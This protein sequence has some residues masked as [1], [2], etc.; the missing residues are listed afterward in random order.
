MISLPAAN[1]FCSSGIRRS[2]NEIFAPKNLNVRRM[3]TRFGGKRAAPFSDM[4]ANS[5]QLYEVL[6]EEYLVLHGSLPES[7]KSRR[8][9]ILDAV[10]REHDEESRQSRLNQRLVPLIYSCIHDLE[11]NKR[12]PRS[13]L[14]L[15]GGGIRSGT[16]ALGVLQGLARHNLLDKFDY[17]STVS[18]GGYIG[19][20]LT[21]WIHRHPR[22]LRG[23]TAELARRT[24][25]QSG[26]STRE[27]HDLNSLAP[28]PEPVRFLR[29]YSNFL[30]P[31]AGALTIDTW[32]FFTI[33]LRNLLL[34]W[35]VLIPLVLCVVGVPRV[36]AAALHIERPTWWWMNGAFIVGFVAL[37]IG[38]A[39]VHFNRPSIGDSADEREVSAEDA[40]KQTR[41]QIEAGIFWSNNRKRF[42][43]L[44]LLPL[45]VAGIALTTYWAWFSRFSFDTEM[46]ISFL[47]YAP[48]WSLWFAFM[49][50]GAVCNLC[51]WAIYAVPHKLSPLIRAALQATRGGDRSVNT[52][53]KIKLR[54]LFWGII[55]APAAGAFGGWLAYWLATRV[56]VF[57]VPATR[58][59]EPRGILR[60][61]ASSHVEL[62]ACFAF[63]IFL[64]LVAVAIVFV[65]AATS[66]SASIKDEDHEWW[67]RCMAWLMLVALGWS[68]F[69]ALVL[70]G[71]TLMFIFFPYVT[72]LGAL[73]GLLTVMLGRSAKTPA[74]EATAKLDWK[75]LAARYA[76]KLAAPV[77]LVFFIVAL[78]FAMNW[79]VKAAAVAATVGIRFIDSYVNLAVSPNSLWQQVTYRLEHFN[80]Q[81][82]A[83]VLLS[84]PDA[85]LYIIST[86]PLLLIL[87]LLLALASIGLFVARLIL[88]L[89]R[90]SLH[91]AYRN[92]LVRAFLGASRPEGE[93]KANPF[94][95]FDPADNIDMHSLRPGFL[96]IDHLVD[97]GGAKKSFVLKIKSGNPAKRPDAPP[98]PNEPQT[99][100]EA[101]RFHA[102]L[103]KKLSRLSGMQRTLEKLNKYEEAE[104]PPKRLLLDLIDGLNRVLATSK[105]H[106]D[107]PAEK[108]SP[109]KERAAPESSTFGEPLQ[110]DILYNRLTLQRFF[111]DEIEPYAFPPPPHTLLHVINLTLNLVKGD[112]LAWQQR[113]AA[114]FTVSPLHAGSSQLGFRRS[115]EYGGFTGGISLGTAATI[116]GAAANPNMGYFSSS[117]LVTFFMT[118]F[119][120][121]LG[122]W[123]GNPGG[124]GDTVL[125]RRGGKKYRV[126]QYP[127]P[128]WSIRPLIAEALG[129]TDAASR[130][131]NLSDGGH[132]ENLALYEMILRRCRFVVVVDGAQ[133]EGGEFNDLGNAVRKIRVDLGIPIHFS[134]FDIF[135]RSKKIEKGTGKYAAIGTIDYKCVDG[136]TAQQGVLIYIKPTIYG[137]EPRDV[138]NYAL[139]NREFPHQ[140]TADQFFDESQFESYRML[141]SHIIE[142]I[143]KDNSGTA[144][145]A[146]TSAERDETLE[147][148]QEQVEI[149]LGQKKCDPSAA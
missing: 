42:L 71:P 63:P 146:I 64:T 62:Y 40:G 47:G 127:Y 109:P 17:L 85:H 48:R 52:D 59:N 82:S 129:L 147:R 53:F 111:S 77:F 65:I 11:K 149:Y 128:K 56:V 54:Q 78:S 116:S 123:L 60:E 45:S 145:C 31:R 58:D 136:D 144:Q 61:Y 86:T 25:S 39:Y 44:C 112:N 101:Q 37:V 32:T 113:K 81:L 125:S 134:Q 7:Y 12:Q 30:T 105:L 68:V 4:S 26:E 72:S 35:T 41:E 88:N 29:S 148:F 124:A 114:S 20:W 140:T 117:A 66:R 23:V 50:F 143:F 75:S 135:P 83:L 3:C 74:T 27:G 103:Y 43:V 131:V 115:S 87:A 79:L 22:G 132:F 5:V 137:D 55:I 10:N 97:V 93:R 36:C 19:S 38:I 1:A 18:G 138:L 107:F 51:G 24:A 67:S 9:E 120:V 108:S 46:S 90:F 84:K 13:A 106:E 70:F 34:N 100:G 142:E 102:H 122:W 94:T 133:D 121:R 76:L 80:D 110:S 96:N 139:R 98:A 8:R 21:A 57:H 73:T 130:Y 6:E 92:R 118:F 89:N 104:E 95:G 91:G 126:Y 69:S 14:C 15:S 99:Q 119:N 49:V 2:R 28:E 33:I 141:G 16:F